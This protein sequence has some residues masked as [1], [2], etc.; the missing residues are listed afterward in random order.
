MCCTRLSV[1]RFK[2]QC[3]AVIHEV[4]YRGVEVVLTRHRRPLAPPA[5]LSASDTD[6]AAEPS[7]AWPET[8]SSR[9]LAAEAA[10]L[11]IDV[12]AVMDTALRRAVGEARAGRWQEVEA[13]WITDYNERVRRGLWSDGSRRF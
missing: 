10:S 3:L 7:L 4:E 8:W 6:T 9:A 11:G 5:S 2:A 1:S 13:D 12:A